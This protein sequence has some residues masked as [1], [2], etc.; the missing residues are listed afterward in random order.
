MKQ[1]V[2]LRQL[3]QSFFFINLFMAACIYS[4]AQPVNGNQPTPELVFKNATL[5][6]GLDGKDGAIYRFANVTTGIDALVTITRRSDPSVKLAAI[7]MPGSGWTKAFQP[8][9]GF[10]GNV[11]PWKTWWMEFQMAFV[12]AGTTNPRRLKNFNVTAIDIDGDGRSIREFVQMEK[13]SGISLAPNNYLIQDNPLSLPALPFPDTSSF[14][15]LGTDKK[16]TGPVQN[17]GNIDTTATSVMATFNYQD[18]DV[19]RFILGGKTGAYSSSAG[20]RMNSLWFRSF[21]LAPPVSL[22]VNL[23]AFTTAFDGTSVTASWSSETERGLSHYILERSTDGREYQQVALIFNKGNTTEK[24]DYQFR[25]KNFPSSTGLLYYRL[26]MVDEDQTTNLSETRIVR[27]NKE[28]ASMQL[29][30]FPNPVQGQAFLTIPPAWQGSKV[31]VEVIAGNGFVVFKKEIQ[32][33]SQTETVQLDLLRPGIYQVRASCQ[34]RSL[35]ATI[36]HQ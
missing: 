29:L 31:L 27:L 21:S 12:D 14:N 5:Y 22:P 3:L 26:R 32:A 36:S 1:T 16:I 25:D 28:N 19:I 23:T 10:N 34:G 7:D 13:V 15:L 18:K 11:A 20:S 2:P 4:Q 8:Q 9:L 17:F 24:R 35:A 33:C 6:A 30:V